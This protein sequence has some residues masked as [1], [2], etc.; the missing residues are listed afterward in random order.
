MRKSLLLV[1]LTALLVFGLVASASAAPADVEGTDYEGAVVKLMALDVLTGYPDGSFGPDKTITR[2]EFAA[3]AV[4]LLGLEDAA[5]YAKGATQFSDVAADHW[6]S[7]YIN[8]AVNKEV[9]KGYPDG[10]FRPE[11]DVTYAEAITILVRALGYGPDVDQYGTWPANYIAKA[12]ELDITED[13]NFYGGAPAKRGDIALMADNSLD[14]DLMVQKGYGDEKTYEIEE[15]KTLLSEKLDVRK[16]DES[17]VEGVPKYTDIA[18]NE[19]TIADKTKES[20]TDYSGTYEVIESI[21]PNEYYGLDVVLWQAGDDADDPIVHIDVKT[22]DDNIIQG[23][24]DEIDT[25]DETLKLED[26]DDEFSLPAELTFIYNTLTLQDKTDDEINALIDGKGK[27]FIKLVVDDN[28][29]ILYMVVTQYNDDDV[30]SAGANDE[31]VTGVINEIDDE[32]VT[33]WVNSSSDKFTFDTEDIQ[34]DVDDNDWKVYVER[35]GEEADL[36]DLE[37]GDVVLYVKN[38]TANAY[39]IVATDAKVVGEL[40]ETDGNIDSV[41]VDGESYDL[42]NDVIFSDSEGDDAV[43]LLNNNQSMIDDSMGEEITLYLNPAGEVRYIV[44]DVE[45]TSE[46]MFAIVT[47]V[48]GE[49]IVGG[50]KGYYVELTDF[51][52]NAKVYKFDDNDLYKDGPYYD[53]NDNGS[54]DSEDVLPGILVRYEIN[55]DGNISDWEYLDY[56]TADS[57][58]DDYDIKKGTV[59][60]VSDDPNKIVTDDGT[61]FATSATK[62]LYDKD[63][64]NDNLVLDPE[65]T[66]WDLVADS[67]LSGEKVIVIADGNKVAYLVLVDNATITSESDRGIA[68]GSGRNADGLYTRLYIEGS[69]YTYNVTVSGYAYNDG[70]LVEFELNEDNEISNATSVSSFVYSTWDTDVA[71][72][73]DDGYMGILTDIDYDAELIDLAQIDANGDEKSGGSSISAALDKDTVIYDV[74]D[75]DDPKVLE[76][77]DLNENDVVFVVVGNDDI[78]TE[79]LLIDEDDLALQ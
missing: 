1:V 65:D 75:K 63:T 76:L 53:A 9:I 19:I 77:S 28:D 64:T 37:E 6:A 23:V 24:F 34:E 39:Y 20:D 16:L 7:G 27:A 45:A 35:N 43:D 50:E 22:D 57:S 4:R 56:T 3:V 18:A 52:G 5:Q 66:D 13:M 74:T 21:D 48:L 2:A 54:N 26:I 73:A 62:V 78:V 10:T 67:E 58:T 8:I 36:A 79:I 68:I 42:A 40:E 71:D 33:L 14:V 15:G 17:T 38:D 25:D 49:S 29:N 41:V 12:A 55:S 51:D 30:D 46:E 11:N 70:I 44:S 47:D 31:I 69:V 59:S 32:D 60:S 72:D 61:F